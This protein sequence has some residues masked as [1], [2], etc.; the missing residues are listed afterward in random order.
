M[1]PAPK[2]YTGTARFLESPHTTPGLLFRP[3]NERGLSCHDVYSAALKPRCTS[4]A[5]RSV[6][7]AWKLWPRAPSKRPSLFW[8][9][10]YDHLRPSF[11]YFPLPARF[12]PLLNRSAASFITS[13]RECSGDQPSRAPAYSRAGALP[14]KPEAISVAASGNLKKC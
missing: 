5:C 3:S 6:L 8:R 4:G 2:C 1:N 12:N 11:P 10:L 9:V 14:I 7:R 13:Y